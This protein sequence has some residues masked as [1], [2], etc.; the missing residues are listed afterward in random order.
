MHKQSVRLVQAKASKRLGATN[1]ESNDGHNHAE[2]QSNIESGME[3]ISLLRNK[4]S[5]R[6][7]R[8]Y[9]QSLICVS[10]RQVNQNKFSKE[11]ITNHTTSYSNKSCWYSNI[12]LE[13]L[14]LFET[15]HKQQELPSNIMH[16]ASLS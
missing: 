12:T 3:V 14:Q 16:V 11:D 4:R 6:L 15:N 5:S 1:L 10:I 7:D 2:R 13:T 9:L 8:L